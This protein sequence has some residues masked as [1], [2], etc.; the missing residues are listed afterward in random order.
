MLKPLRSLL[1][2]LIY[3]VRHLRNETLTE[4][5]CVERDTTGF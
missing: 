5:A 1:M 4:T 2:N 3:N